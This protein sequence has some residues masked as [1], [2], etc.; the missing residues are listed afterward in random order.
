MRRAFSPKPSGILLGL[1]VREFALQQ[2]HSAMLSHCARCI[3]VHFLCVSLQHR[4]GGRRFA[5]DEVLLHLQVARLGQEAG[6]CT[7]WKHAQRLPDQFLA[8]CIALVK[9]GALAPQHLR[10][11]M[12]AFRLEHSRRCFVGPLVAVMLTL[13]AAD[14]ARQV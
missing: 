6:V 5:H 10:S 11:D 7:G 2:M 4:R 13:C 9:H 3:G 8:V 12:L 14:H 1:R